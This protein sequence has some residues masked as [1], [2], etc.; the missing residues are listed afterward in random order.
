MRCRSA[1]PPEDGAPELL[2]SG[3]RYSIPQ[4]RERHLWSPEAISLLQQACRRSDYD[5]YLQFAGLI[6]DQEEQQSTLRGLFR[7]KDGDP[8]SLEDVSRSPKL[9]SASSQ[10]PCPLAR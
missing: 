8:I 1:G 10:G 4:R 3:G 7:I 9:S 5:L 2:A 6:N